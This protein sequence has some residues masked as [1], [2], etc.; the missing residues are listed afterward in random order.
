M[1]VVVCAQSVVCPQDRRRASCQGFKS[2]YVKKSGTYNWFANLCLEWKPML[3]E[4]RV[5]QVH[6]KVTT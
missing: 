4:R 3:G 2:G 6:S 1:C 5:E